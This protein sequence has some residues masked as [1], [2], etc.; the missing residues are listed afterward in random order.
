MREWERDNEGKFQL[1]IRLGAENEE[2]NESERDK[3]NESK[4]KWEKINFGNLI[5]ILL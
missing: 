1:K 2:C 5:R 4:S 3:N